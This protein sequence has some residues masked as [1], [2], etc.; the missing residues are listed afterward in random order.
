MWGGGSLSG[1]GSLYDW[2]DEAGNALIGGGF[3][4]F[5]DAF[6]NQYQFTKE[7]DMNQ[8]RGEQKVLDPIHNKYLNDWG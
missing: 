6:N 2:R 5:K 3:N 8:L 7:W 1:G 4:N